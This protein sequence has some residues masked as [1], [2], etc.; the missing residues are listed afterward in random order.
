MFLEYEFSV[1][2]EDQSTGH[3][4]EAITQEGQKPP[5]PGSA[6]L[7]EKLLTVLETQPVGTIAMRLQDFINRRPN[8]VQFST[9]TKS[10]LFDPISRVAVFHVTT[11]AGRS[12]DLRLQLEKPA[13]DGLYFIALV[14]DVSK[15]ARLHVNDKVARDGM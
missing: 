7:I 4:A 6:S 14:W 10:F 3:R 1:S 9:R 13:A 12:V 15:G 8:I 11:P 5:Q 2:E